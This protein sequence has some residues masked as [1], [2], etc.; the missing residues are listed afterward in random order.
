MKKMTLL[1]SIFSLILLCVFLA[2]K[3]VVGCEMVGAPKYIEIAENF[4]V[5]NAFEKSDHKE[6]LSKFLKARSRVEETFGKLISSPKIVITQNASGAQNLGS[7]DTATA[8]LSIIGE[9]LVFGPQGN[10]IDVFAH[11]LVHAEVHHRLGWFS[12]ITSMPVWFNEG[13]ALV[14]DHRPPYLPEN[15]YI[16]NKEIEEVKSKKYGYQ[17]FDGS[18]HKNYQSARMAVAKVNPKSLYLK[19]EDIRNGKSFT[20]AFEM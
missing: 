5:S 6:F 11:E 20:D 12:Q 13:I 7:N 3:D 8:H 19:L 4:Y 18:A 10:N 9:C 15:I 17:F 16:T 1:A 2:H 14:V